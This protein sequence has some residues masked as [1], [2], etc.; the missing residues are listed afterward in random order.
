[1]PEDG[2][3][4]FQRVAFP[5]HGGLLPVRPKQTLKRSRAA[6]REAYAKTNPW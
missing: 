3:I 2:G 6:G 1:M 4:C 5:K